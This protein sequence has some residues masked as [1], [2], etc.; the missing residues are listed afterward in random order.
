MAFRNGM[1]R[2]GRD[3]AWPRREAWWGMLFATLLLWGASGGVARAQSDFIIQSIDNDFPSEIADA[4][5]NDKNLIIFF[6][7]AGCPYCDKMRARVFPDP[8]VDGYFTKHFVMI[9]SNI[10]GSLSVVTPDGKTMTES[11]FGHKM[12][13]RATPVIVFY[14]RQGHDVLRTTG[15]LDPQQFY[16]A[17]RYVEDGVYKS[18]KSFFRYLRDQS[19]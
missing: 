12:R 18:G 15:Y 10:R 11:D 4:A 2:G 7:Q 9:E 13:V 17:G 16:L 3:R 1:A 14:D 6:H 19:Q 5:G 8:K